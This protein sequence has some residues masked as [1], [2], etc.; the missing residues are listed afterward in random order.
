MYLNAEDNSVRG[1]SWEEL[2]TSC[3]YLP[4]F[5]G[6]NKVYLMFQILNMAQMAVEEAMLVPVRGDWA[7][8]SVA[9]LSGGPYSGETLDRMEYENKTYICLR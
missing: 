8:R 2:C 3:Y 4:G 9:G 7:R 6:G 1:K 5:D